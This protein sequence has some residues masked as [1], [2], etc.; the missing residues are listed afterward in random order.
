MNQQPLKYQLESQREQPWQSHNMQFLQFQL[1]SPL[2][3][4][5][6]QH[7]TKAVKPEG[8]TKAV[9]NALATLAKAS[10]KSSELLWKE[11][12]IRRH[13]AA[14][15]PDGSAARMAYVYYQRTIIVGY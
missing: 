13:V 2:S 4:A 12:H 5:I 1:V 10:H 11:V 15:R 9:H 3:K 8:S 14:S 6:N 7:A